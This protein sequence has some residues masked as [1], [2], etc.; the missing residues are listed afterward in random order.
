V[1]EIGSYARDEGIKKRKIKN[2][3]IAC[4]LTFKVKGS[5]RLERNEN[6][7]MHVCMHYNS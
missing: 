5:L 3:Y 4:A 6:S 2:K 1:C 7:P